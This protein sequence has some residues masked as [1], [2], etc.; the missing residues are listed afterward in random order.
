LATQTDAPEAEAEQ[1]KRARH[2]LQ[3]GDTVWYH[4]RQNPEGEWREAEV[5]TS[6]PWEGGRELEPAWGEGNDV[7]HLA[8][9][10]DRRRHNSNRARVLRVNVSEGTA[11]GQYQLSKPAG[12]DAR[13]EEA[14]A[15]K[16]MRDEL[17]R[18]RA[19]ADFDNSTKPL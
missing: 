2:P 5:V 8:V 14:L 1:R 11:P 6:E 19:R 12:A 4:L 16:H 3:P 7:V 18:E 15:R 9:N 17:G 10:V 13:F